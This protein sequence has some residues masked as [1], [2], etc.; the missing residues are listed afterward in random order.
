LTNPPPAFANKNSRKQG[1][2]SSKYQA[3]GETDSD[4]EQHMM[5]AEPSFGGNFNLQAQK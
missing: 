2:Q 5:H 3:V 4:D 1:G